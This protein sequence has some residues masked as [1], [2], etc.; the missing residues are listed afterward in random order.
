[1]KE[2]EKGISLVVLVITVIVLLIIAAITVYQGN[3]IIRST[4]LQ[5]LKTDLLLI[6]AKV[7]IY[8]EQANFESNNS[9]LKGTA[10]TESWQGLEAN[11]EKIRSLSKQDLVDM[12]LDI[13]AED[14]DYIVDYQNNEVY[15]K[16][17]YQTKKDKN[18]QSKTYYK[19]SE[20]VQLSAEDTTL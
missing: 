20:I 9:M 7:Q 1:M 11:N 17:G 12:G 6:Q 3:E 5:S 13:K 15:Y 16:K 10:L 4:R 19:A 14:G 2:T 18:G 8:S